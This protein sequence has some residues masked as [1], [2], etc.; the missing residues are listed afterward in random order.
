[1]C[2]MICQ[3]GELKDLVKK[4]D[5]AH[6]CA[7]H[8]KTVQKYCPQNDLF[9]LYFFYCTELCVSRVRGKVHLL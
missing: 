8:R 6:S 2:C 9:L 1:M 4:R 3:K 7:T 5:Q